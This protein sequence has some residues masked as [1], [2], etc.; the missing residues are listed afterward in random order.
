MNIILI[1][2]AVLIVCFMIGVPIAISLGASAIIAIWFG[3][4]LPIDLI[5]QKAF[6]SLDSFSL[7]AIPFFI[8]AGILMGRGG[9]SKRL[10]N[11]AT[12]LVGWITGGLSLV[13]IVACMFFAA[14]AGSGP[15]TVAA[16]GS[17]MI[18]AMIANKYHQ[19]FSAGATAAA[20]SIGVII[21]PSIPFVV[22]GAVG[23]VSVGAMFMAGIIPGVLI[24]V[25]LLLTAYLM[26][27]KRGYKPQEGAEKF[28]FKDVLTAT[29]DAKWALLVPVIILGGIYG[30]VF[31]PTEAAV[32]AVVYAIIVGVFI[33]RELDWKGMYDSF[34]ETILINATTMIIISFSVSFAFFMTLE[35]IPNTI[36]EG[37]MNLTSNPIFI[38]VIIIIL[39]LVVGMFIDTISALIILTPI[40]L[41]VVTSVGIDPV[42]FGV[43]LVVSL[44]IGFVTP[45]LGV[46]LFVASS[47]GKVKFE[48]VAVGV[49]P[50]VAVMI[51][52]LFIIAFIPALSMFLPGLFE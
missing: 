46:N 49:L 30:G 12:A 35:Q 36:A 3:T 40:L 1:L 28:I 20:G 48:Q 34:M 26:S 14:I 21:P 6:T 22:Y 29:W 25:A 47:V 9:I 10:L 44:A 16:I 4:D 38:L 2:F 52:C 7:L 50:F 24:G 18:P 43:V 11:L 45:P 39:L 19:G 42:H 27:K 31:S 17:F 41:P 15:A 33:H 13:T 37:L 5:A 8:L 51:I 23:S 32:T